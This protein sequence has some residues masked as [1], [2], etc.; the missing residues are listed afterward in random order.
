MKDKQR[1]RLLSAHTLDRL[2]FRF[3]IVAEKGHRGFS[4]LAVE[5]VELQYRIVERLPVDAGKNRVL[6]INYMEIR[7]RHPLSPGEYA[8]I[9]NS[10]SDIATFRS[11]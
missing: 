9:G 11:K 6:F 7:P 10:L 4:P 2:A 3:T 5:N 8:I 1:A